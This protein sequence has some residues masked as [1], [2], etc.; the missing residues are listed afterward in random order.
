LATKATTTRTRKKAV[1]AETKT[2]EPDEIAKRAYELYE[3]GADGGEMEHWLQAE[4]ELAGAT[5]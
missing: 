5:A 2:P 3:S 1:E 4:R